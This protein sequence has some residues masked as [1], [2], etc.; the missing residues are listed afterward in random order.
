MTK[1][2]YRL[3]TVAALALT[4]LPSAAFAQDSPANVRPVAFDR[5]LEGVGVP[6]SSTARVGMSRG[7]K[8]A[9][10]AA[11]GAAAG[12]VFGEVVL[13]Q[14]LDIEHGP[15]ML[16]GAGAFAVVGALIAKSMAGPASPTAIPRKA[17]SIAPVLSKSTKAVVVR[18]SL[19]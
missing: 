11:I 12:L 8:I 13:G 17:I 7:G 10:G 9:V 5:A 6:T 15:D 18:L 16:I 3:L 1:P 14:G 19:K 4:V 2:T